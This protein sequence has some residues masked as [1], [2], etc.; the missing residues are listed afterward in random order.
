MD[1]DYVF[2]GISVEVVTAAV[3][4]VDFS[5]VVFII[6]VVFVLSVLVL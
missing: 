5:C 6:C 4:Y 3:E 2:V 1:K